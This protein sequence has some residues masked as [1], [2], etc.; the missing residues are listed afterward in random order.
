MNSIRQSYENTYFTL[1]VKML[2]LNVS[3]ELALVSKF[4]FIAHFLFLTV[5]A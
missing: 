4:E 1:S 2:D 3:I 5:A